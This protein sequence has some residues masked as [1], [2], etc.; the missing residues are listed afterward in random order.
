[1]IPYA[2]SE[3][4]KRNTFA[5]IQNLSLQAELKKAH[6]EVFE[7]RGENA[8]LQ[9]ELRIAKGEL[10]QLRGTL[11]IVGNAISTHDIIAQSSP[12]FY[13]LDEI[14]NAVAFYF[15]LAPESL[16]GNMKVREITQ[17]RQMAMYIASIASRA[18]MAAIGRHLGNRDHTTVLH[19]VR[20]IKRLQLEDPASAQDIALITDKLKNAPSGALEAAPSPDPP[21]TPGA[22]SL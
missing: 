17:A 14:V 5:K 13:S 11:T 21:S 2:G 10:V 16:R 19:G 18:S 9:R 1:M 15:G 3:A 12:G 7:L 6:R 20:K 22:A 8:R 4:A